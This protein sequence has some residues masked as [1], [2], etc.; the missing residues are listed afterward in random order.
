MSVLT[1]GIKRCS[2]CGSACFGEVPLRLMQNQP[3]LAAGFS[4]PQT[5]CGTLHRRH[6]LTLPVPA[7]G[8]VPGA[9]IPDPQQLWSGHTSARCLALSALSSGPVNGRSAG[10]FAF[11]S[12]RI[13]CVIGR[14][15]CGHSSS[16]RPSLTILIAMANGVRPSLS[17]SHRIWWSISSSGRS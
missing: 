3:I 14:K 8:L 13:A 12:S 10:R 1:C 17:D 7:S 2:G 15:V 9:G 16:L 6:S 11:T 5:T 4:Y